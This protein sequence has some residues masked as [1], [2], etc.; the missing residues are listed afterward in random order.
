MKHIIS[1]DTFSHT[2]DE[3]CWC[4]P[5]ICTVEGETLCIHNTNYN[6]DIE[7]KDREIDNEIKSN[8]SN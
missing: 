2:E 3:T 4:S 7:T 8:K 1:D 5:R 6:I